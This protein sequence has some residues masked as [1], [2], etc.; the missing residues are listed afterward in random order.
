V[1]AF[2]PTLGFQEMV[3]LF[4]LG[5]L[6][7]GRNLPEVGR[8]VGRVVQQLK[9]GMAEFKDAMDREDSVRELR[10]TIRD[11][12]DEVRRAGAMPRAVVNPGAVVRDF[13]NE[14]VRDAFANGDDGQA[15]ARGEHPTSYGDETHRA[16]VDPATKDPEARPDTPP[17]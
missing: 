14:T 7:F 5:I 15:A 9:R 13:A 12:R 1:L 2:L 16:A 11:T 8:K 3:L 10:E 17:A 6:L 4:L